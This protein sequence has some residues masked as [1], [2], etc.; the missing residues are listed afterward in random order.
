L[1]SFFVLQVVYS[2]WLVVALVW[3]VLG[4]VFAAGSE[5]CLETAPYLFRLAIAQVV[6]LLPLIGI[7]IALEIEWCIRKRPFFSAEARRLQKQLAGDQGDDGPMT[8]GDASD[9]DTEG[10]GDG[11]NAGGN[12]DDDGDDDGDGT[13]EDVSDDED[14][15]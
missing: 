1:R 15:S 9:S 3:L 2:L 6:I 13:E 14:K 10:G 4:I 7:S 5:P 12:D 8:E 11:A